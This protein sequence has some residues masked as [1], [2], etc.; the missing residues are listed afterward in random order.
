MQR[1]GAR[2]RCRWRQSPQ[3][4]TR[5]GLSSSRQNYTAIMGSAPRPVNAAA[6]RIEHTARRRRLCP[7]R[8]GQYPVQRRHDNRMPRRNPMRRTILAALAVLIAGISASFAVES[9]RSRSRR[10]DSGTAPGSSSAR[11]PAS[12]RTPALRSRCSTPRAARRRSPPSSR[13]ASTSPCRTASSARSA[14]M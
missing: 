5:I 8:A 6:G 12:S 14:P 7:I 9:S 10:R 11:P 4:G 2:G 13:A 1:R 3:V